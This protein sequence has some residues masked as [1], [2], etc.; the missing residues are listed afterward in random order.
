MSSVDQQSQ[1]VVGSNNEWTTAGELEKS[2]KA[3]KDARRVIRKKL[4]AEQQVIADREAKARDDE[5]RKKREEKAKSKAEWE[6]RRKAR[7][8][9]KNGVVE[10]KDTTVKRPASPVSTEESSGLA[11]QLTSTV[12][13]NSSATSL[14]LSPT[15]SA[16]EIVVE[17]L[18]RFEL[19]AE[20]IYCF[21]RQ[22]PEGTMIRCDNDD[23]RY[24]YL[25]QS[26][27]GWS[28]KAVK[29]FKELEEWYC[30]ECRGEGDLKALVEAEAEKKSAAAAAAAMKKSKKAARAGQNGHGGMRADF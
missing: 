22:N 10:S 9:R 24:L 8:D 16:V 29:R 7:E 26:C 14:Q 15:L 30:G 11:A 13:S 4:E 1:T 6:A 28:N 27:M 18:E 20:E 25:H 2:K 23:C 17:D 5:I 21:C 3:E 19:R 12:I